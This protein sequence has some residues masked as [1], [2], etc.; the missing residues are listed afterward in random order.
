MESEVDAATAQA[1]GGTPGSTLIDRADTAL[2]G[3]APEVEAAPPGLTLLP[4]LLDI[5]EPAVDS[6]RIWDVLDA[7]RA[8]IRT[9]ATLEEGSAAWYE[10]QAELVG[11]RALYHRLFDEEA[12]LAD[13]PRRLALVGRPWFERFEDGGTSGH[14]RTGDGARPG[15]D[16]GPGADARPGAQSD[17]QPRVDPGA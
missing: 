8:T 13:V 7:W 12:A 14:G 4:S 5:P 1:E 3:M 15:A 16:A 10:C 11:L 6:P 17:D 2:E 9:V